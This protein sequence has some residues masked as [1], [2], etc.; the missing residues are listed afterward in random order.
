[1]LSYV[2][3]I[4]SSLEVDVG[5]IFVAEGR[6]SRGQVKHV[7]CS[8]LFFKRGFLKNRTYHKD[9]RVWTNVYTFATCVKSA[10]K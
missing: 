8:Y 1:M 4:G 9:D 3:Q 7:A 6:A 2:G 10:L 5:R